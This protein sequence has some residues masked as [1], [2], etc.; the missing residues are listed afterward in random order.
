MVSCD[1]KLSFLLPRKVWDIYVAGT[2]LHFYTLL[3]FFIKFDLYTNL[4]IQGRSGKGSIFV[5]A[6]GNGGRDHDNCN[7]DGYTNSIWTL[8]ISSATENGYVPWYSEACSSTL[9]TT[10]SS[11]TSGEKQVCSVT[12]ELCVQ[13][14]VFWHGS[15]T[16]CIKSCKERTLCVW[17]VTYDNFTILISLAISHAM[18][19]LIQNYLNT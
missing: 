16:V 12:T 8:S 7:C 15:V 5:W 14:S 17:S 4:L 2:K 6:S 10:Y 19:C 1:S 18:C 3:T 13:K 11:G 9:A